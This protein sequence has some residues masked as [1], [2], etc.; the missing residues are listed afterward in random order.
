MANTFFIIWF[1][2]NALLLVHILHELLLVISAL[3]YK[4]KRQLL[5]VNDLPFVTIQ[6]PLYNEKYVVIR[7]LET[8][9]KIDYP[10]DKLEIQIL[11]DSNDE[12]T[13][14]ISDFLNR[15]NTDHFI[16]IRR[17]KRSGFKAG[18]LDYGLSICKGEFIAIFDADFVPPA[19]FLKRTIPYF[20]ESKVGVVQTRWSHI[21]EDYTLITRAQ[22]IMLNTHFSVEQLGR[23]NS[24]SFINFNGTAGIWR[25]ECINDAGGWQADT[26]TE[27]LDLSFRAQMKHWKFEYLFDLKSPA[28]LPI[29]FDAYRTQQYRWSKG[30][31]ECL[32]K[33]IK[34]LWDSDVAKKSK[35]VGSFHLLNSSIYLLVIALLMLSPLVHYFRE[36]DMISVPYESYLSSS[37]LIVSG[38]LIVIFFIGNHLGSS[39]KLKSALLFVPSLFTFFSMTTGI[40]VYMSIGVVEG[41]LGRKSEFVR[42]PKFGNTKQ[43]LQKVKIGYDNKNQFNTTIIEFICFL[44]GFYWCYEGGVAL[45]PIIFIYGLIILTGFSMSLFFKKWSFKW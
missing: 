4:K 45:N 38:C 19:D 9:A 44:Y 28:E 17:E 16:H 25:K 39:K 14:L 13:A 6:L 33:N 29:T 35:I 32:R 3:R 7:L 31:A 21:N 36:R 18:A 34:Q 1:I 40:S 5:Q 41:Y 12:T 24:D 22:A 11:D 8:I 30:A 26:L 15:S 23:Y 27:D 2:I 10:T 42:T 43:L 20:E 37:G